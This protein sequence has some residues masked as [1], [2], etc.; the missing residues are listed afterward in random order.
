VTDQDR[1]RDHARRGELGK[2]SEAERAALRPAA[3]ELAHRIVYDVVTRRVARGRGHGS[4][5]L[6]LRHVGECCLDGFHND[7]EA[8]VELL[9]TSTQRIT[10]LERWL[11]GRAPNAAIDGYRH[12]R[13]EIGALQRPRMTIWLEQ[14]LG[15]DP[16][17]C[18]L[19]VQILAWVG[20]PG[21]AGATLWPL[22]AWAV[23]RA[24]FTGDH[25]ASTPVKV[26]D[27]VEQVL[28]VMRRRSAWFR[29]HVQNPLEKK[30]AP[31]GG[32]PGERPGE[33]RP[34]VPVDSGE[35]GEDW[36]TDLAAVA[37]AAIQGGLNCGDDPTTTV[38]TVLSKLFVSGTGAEEI[39]RAPGAGSTGAELVSALL[40]DSAARP[41]LVEEVLAIVQGLED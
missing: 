8:V 37:V 38:V 20:T 7:L 18:R 19:A 3:F 36:A 24:T 16:W 13:G 23:E 28:A 21:G 40:G 2:I 22:D 27:E 11:A 41:A 9:L 31:V 5:A 15:G 35:A 17:L 25:R 30:V 26:L 33:P 12:R 6:D 34:L 4:C 29:D 39:G 32:S 10:D 1:L 14:G